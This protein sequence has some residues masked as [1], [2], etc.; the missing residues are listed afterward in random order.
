MHWCATSCRSELSL[1]NVEFENR[2]VIFVKHSHFTVREV[3]G[4]L[5]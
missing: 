2:F 5:Q 1:E 3:F 4:F